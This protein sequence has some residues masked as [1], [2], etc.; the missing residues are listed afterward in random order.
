MAVVWQL[1]C[2]HFDGGTLVQGVL[3][4]DSPYIH[5]E[6]L[7]R[8][9]NLLKLIKSYFSGICKDEE[10][11]IT[12]DNVVLSTTTDHR[13][14]FSLMTDLHLTHLPL[15]H[16]A[17]DS[18]PLPILQSYP[19]LFEASQSKF[20]VI[21]DIDDTI[22]E[23]YS[24]DFFKRVHTVSLVAPRKRKVIRPTQR[25]YDK[26]VESGA[27][28][29]YVSKSESNLFG[30]ITSFIDHHDRPVGVLLLTPYLRSL[31]LF[32]PKKGKDFKINHIRFIFE[33]SEGKKF[34]L[35]GDD[36]QRDM[37][38]YAIIAEEYRERMI[39]VY[40]RQ[41]KPYRSPRQRRLWEVLSSK[42]VPAEYFK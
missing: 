19:A 15:V 34:V 30:F 22:M 24:A 12:V 7:S 36:S 4:K 37:E 1:S 23:S 33:R 39:K 28:F 32:R 9:K 14:A 38:V 21:S 13:G 35:L 11:S 16:R 10:I 5:G 42:G 27:R 17:G 6:H 18:R 8:I 2:V 20:D 3:L 26:F 41:T 31:D 25:L 29:F 40:I